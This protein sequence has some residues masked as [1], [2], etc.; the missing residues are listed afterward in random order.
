M[1]AV[2][3]IVVVLALVLLVAAEVSDETDLYL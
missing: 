2:L 3:L 1:V